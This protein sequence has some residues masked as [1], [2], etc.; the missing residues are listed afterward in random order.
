[1]AYLEISLVLAKTVWYFDFKP[2]PGDLGNVGLSDKGEF[3]IYDIWLS[4]HDGPWLTFTPR[5]TLSEDFPG[6]EL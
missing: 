6:L 5:T 3:R 2:A 4:T 1:M